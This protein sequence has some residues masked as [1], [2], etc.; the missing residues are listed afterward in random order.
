MGIPES[1]LIISFYLGYR[2]DSRYNIN[3][4]QIGGKHQQLPFE[5]CVEFAEKFLRITC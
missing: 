4:Y 3:T 5:G 2:V 1:G